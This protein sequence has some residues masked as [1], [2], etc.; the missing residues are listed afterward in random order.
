MCRPKKLWWRENVSLL[1]IAGIKPC[2]PG[3]FLMSSLLCCVSHRPS[4]LLISGV[5][6]MGR[7]QAVTSCCFWDIKMDALTYQTCWYFCE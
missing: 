5:A 6:S 3:P 7:Q 4:L 2:L 1:L